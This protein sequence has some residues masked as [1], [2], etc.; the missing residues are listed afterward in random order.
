MIK[1]DV[2]QTVYTVDG[3]CSRATCLR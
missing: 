3:E 1:L 2:R